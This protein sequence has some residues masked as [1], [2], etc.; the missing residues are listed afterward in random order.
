MAVEQKRKDARYEIRIAAE[1]RHARGTLTGTTRNLSLGGVCVE[2]PQLLKEGS[3]A[4]LTLFIVED[5]VESEGTKGLSLTATVQ[6]TAEGD[7]GYYTVG[8]KFGNLS[9]AQK[10][11]LENALKHAAP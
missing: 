2:L 3:L 6:W 7:R 5:D 1:V 10:T 9:T 4:Q 8:L 11:A